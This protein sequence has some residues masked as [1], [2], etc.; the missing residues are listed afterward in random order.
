MVLPSGLDLLSFYVGKDISSIIET[1]Y[2][3]NIITAVT[4]DIQIEKELKLLNIDVKILIKHLQYINMTVKKDKNVKYEIDINSELIKSNNLNLQHCVIRKQFCLRKNEDYSTIF[5][6]F[7]PSLPT[8]T[9]TVS[10]EDAYTYF[11]LNLYL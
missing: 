7:Y 8:Y 1:E 6:T 5:Q 10:L 4:D 3:N 9:T 2:K 11:I